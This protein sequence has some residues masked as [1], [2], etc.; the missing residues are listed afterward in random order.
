MKLLVITA[1]AEYAKDIKNI[2]K[3]ANVKSY[4]FQEVIGFKNPDEDVTSS[5][6]FGT[7]MNENESVI[8]FAFIPKENEVKVFELVDEFNKN[9]ETLSQIHVAVL[10][11]EKSN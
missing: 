9:Q 11:I 1:I 6:W 5:N 3:Q 10:K 4:S 8:F 7:E 2:L